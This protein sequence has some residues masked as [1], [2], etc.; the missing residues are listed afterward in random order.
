MA[1]GLRTG[2]NE[3]LY[4]NTGSH[5][6]PVWS[7]ITIATDVDLPFDR[8]MG[9]VKSRTSTQVKNVAGMLTLP[10]D[11]EIIS[12]TSNA[13]YAVLRDAF[14]NATV[15]EFA[16]CDQAIASSGAMYWKQEYLLK[17]FS[18]TQKLENADM[19]KIKAVPSY[20]GLSGSAATDGLWVDVA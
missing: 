2:V 12:D 4:R 16:V 1:A 11:F 14:I 20:V 18:K 10:L 5:G 6:S 8:S 9:E 3:K 7:E 19:T 15:M 17:E 13:A